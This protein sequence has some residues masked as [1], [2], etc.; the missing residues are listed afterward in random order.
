MYGVV[1]GNDLAGLSGAAI[2]VVQ[3]EFIVQPCTGTAE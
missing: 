3:P 1:E 2:T